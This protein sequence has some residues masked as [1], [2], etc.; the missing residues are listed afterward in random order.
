MAKAKLVAFAGSTR[1]GSFN[2]K[3]IATA[4]EFARAAGAEVTLVDLA[5]YPMPLFDGDLESEQGL[6]ENAAALKK[7]F[8]EADGI[9]LSSPEYNA[10][11]TAV[12]KNTIDWL[13]RPGAV[14]GSVFR[15][16]QGLL[17]S[18]SPGGLGGL[19]GLNHI[20]DVLEALGVMI[21]PG[22][23]AISAAH[24]AFDDQGQLQDPKLGEAVQGLVGQLVTTVTALKQQHANV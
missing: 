12:L 9:I 15:G 8:A 1:K 22:Q 13:S 5:D 11:M 19:R 4:A 20:R 10:S 16:K 14:E 23:R 24:Q 18:A 17:L 3:L 7:I 6:P 21:L 2:K